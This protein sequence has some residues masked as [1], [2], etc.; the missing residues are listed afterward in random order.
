MKITYSE[1]ADAAYI[2]L[3]EIGPGEAAETVPWG[4][5]DREINLDLDRDGKLVGIEILD[6]SRLLR[7]HHLISARKP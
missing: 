2:Y 5:G 3:D 7:E 6:A 4:S 1:S